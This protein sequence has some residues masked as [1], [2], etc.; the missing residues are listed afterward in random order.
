MGELYRVIYTGQLR[1]GTE[2]QVAIERFCERFKVAEEKARKVMAA[3]RDLTLKKN[4]EQAKAEKYRQA[5]E[6]IGMIVRLEP[7]EPVPAGSGL[8]LEPIGEEPAT[9]GETGS[10]TPDSQEATQILSTVG[11][12]TTCPKCGSDRI[13][14]QSCLDCGIIIPKYL[15]RQAAEAEAAATGA[16]EEQVSGDSAN[17]YAAPRAGLLEEAQQGELSGPEGR[18]AGHGWYWIR[19]GFWHFRQNPLAWI[20]TLVLWLVLSI[21]LSLVPFVGSLAITLFSPVILA[22]FMLG[23]AAQEHGDDFEISHLFAGFS[24]SVGQLVLV[25]LLYLVGL[26]VVVFAGGMLGGGMMIGMLGGIDAMGNADPGAVSQAM[27]VGTVLLMSLLML[28][29]TLPLMMAYWFAPALVA[30]EGMSALA[31]MR[32]SFSGCLKNILPFLLYGVIALLLF[33]VGAIPVGLGLL[34][35]LPVITASV[36]TSY[37]DIFYR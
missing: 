16:E 25:G 36:Y 27:G 24:S 9:A 4:L 37:R 34:I 12:G 18:P 22:G 10:G 23:S 31:A 29:L 33:V 8:A 2:K 7:M 28:G 32:M 35:V 14:D 15:A 17:P 21:G 20:I 19:R 1:L 11:N 6:S 5:L 26:I 30:M 3:R 13:K